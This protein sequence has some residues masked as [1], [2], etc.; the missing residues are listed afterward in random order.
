MGVPKSKWTSAE[1]EALRAGIAKYGAGK[2]RNIKSDPYFT[3][4]L[5]SRSNIDLK[6]KWRNMSESRLLKSKPSEDAPAAPL[7]VTQASASSNSAAHDAPANAVDGSSKC[8]VDKKTAS[9]YDTMI[10]EAL[11]TLKDPYGSTT[12]AIASF[13]EQKHELAQTFRSLLSSRLRRL[14]KQGKLEK[15][16]NCYRIRKAIT[17]GVEES[18]ARLKEL[19]PK[20]FISPVQEAA[21]YTA[22][23]IADAERK[24]LTAV[25]AKENEERV[26]E[27]LD[28]AKVKLEFAQVVYDKYSHEEMFQ[29]GG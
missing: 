20:T 27:M 2:W 12:S 28:D 19:Q 17:G 16:Q 11:S 10:Y 26:S 15:V 3:Q 22:R 1:E 6:D 4:I 14:A 21:E 9:K 7:L 25:D 18:T 29:R 23:V 24:L 8:L 5:I 13:I